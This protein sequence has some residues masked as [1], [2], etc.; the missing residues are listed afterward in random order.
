MTDSNINNLL[1]NKEEKENENKI[2]NINDL[3]NNNEEENKE[4]IEENKRRIGK[5]KI[6]TPETDALFQRFDNQPLSSLSKIINKSNAGIVDFFDNRFLGDQRSFDEIL[7]NRSRLINEAKEKNEKISEELTKTKTSQVIRGSIT[8]PLKA[9]NETVEFVDDIYDYL[10][11]NPYDNNDLIDYS[12]FEREDDGAFFYIPQAITQF[13]LPMGIFSKGLKGIKNPWT[14]NLIA[15]FLTDFIVEDPY[16]QNLYN[17][18]DEYEGALE[19]IIDIFKMPASI[20]KADDDISPIEARL[21]KAFGG[22]V[23]G[24]VLTGLSVALKAFR[25]SK[26][27]PRI[28]TTLEQK[29]KLKFQDLGIDNAGNELLDVKVIDLL[30]PLDI[31][32]TSTKP[33]IYDLP[34]TRG[35]GKFYHG[36]SQEI[37]LFEGGEAISS[38]NIYGNGFYTTDDLITGSKYQKKGKKQILKPEIPIAKGIKKESDLPYGI[39]S[40]LKKLNITNQELNQLTTPSIKVPSSNRLRDLA[41]QAR[42]FPIDN[43]FSGGIRTIKENFNKI[44]DRLDELADNPPRTPDFKPITYEITE[45]QPVN[46]YDLDQTID[47][48]LKTFVNNFDDSPFDDIVSLAANNLGNNYTL[49]ELFDEIRAYSNARGVSSNTVIDDIFGSFQDYF[50]EKGFGGFTHEGGKKAGK[51]KRLHQVRIYFDP[52]NQ[53]DLNK[54][55]FDDILPTPEVGDKIESTFNPTIT[56]GGV[57]QLEDYILNISE[58]FK[59]TDELGKWARSVSLGDMF[60]ASQ[61][62]TNGQAIEAAQFFLQEFGPFKKTTNGKLINN[63]RYLPSTTITINQLMNKNGERV[64]NLSTALHNAIALKNVDLIKEIKPAFLKEVQLLKDIVYLNKGV[65]SLTSQTLGARRIAGDLRDVGATAEDFGKKSRGTENIEDINKQFIEDEGVSEIDQTFNKIFDLVE[66]GDEEA[67]LALTR[68]TKYLNIAG[69]NPEVMKHMVK[70]GLLLKGVEFTNEIFINSILSGPPTHIVNLLS[71]SLNTLAKPLTQSLGAA[72]ITFRK[73]MNITFPETILKR[74]DNL[75][76]RP[77]FNTDEFIKGWKQFIYMSQSLGDAFNIARKAFQVNENVLDRGAMVSD[78][79]RVSRNINAEDIRNFANQNIVTRSTVKPFLDTRIAETWIPS[80][81]NNFRR[82]NGFGSRMLITEDE[83]LKQVNFRSYVKAESWEQGI[84]KGLQGEKLKNYIQTQSEKVFKIVDTGSTRK[85]PTSITDLYKKA[86]DYAAEVTF[87][88]DLDPRSFSGG[89]QNFAKHPYGRVVF[90]FVRTPINIFKTQMRY[91]FAVNTVMS[92]YR[93]ALRSTDP[94]IAARARGEMYLAGGFLSMGALIARDMENPFAEVGMTGGGPNTVGFGDAI[95]ANRILVKQLKEEGWQ[96]YS[97]RFLVRDSDGEIVLTKSGKPKYKYISFKRL[98]PWSGL[99][100]ILAD[101]VDVEGQIGS[102]N[103]NDFA[104]AFVVSVARNLT[105]RTFLRGL[106]EVAEAIHNPYALQSLLARRVANIINPVSG[107]G[108]SLKKATDKTKFDTTYY[109]ADEM[110]TG[111]RQILNEL[112]RTMP[113]YN[114]DLE[115]DRNWLT[116]AVVKY[117]SGLGPDTFDILNPI[118][119]TTTKDN[120]V[121]SVIN[122]LNITLQPPKK[123]FLRRQGIQNSGIELTRK[124]YSSY[125]KYLSFDTKSFNFKTASGYKIQDGDRLI[126]SLY[127]R[128]NEPDMKAYIKTAMGEGID[129]TNQDTMVAVQDNARAIISKEI[130]SI[131]SNFKVKARNEWL[132]LPE[133]KKLFAKY[134]ANMEVISNETTKATLNNLEEIKNL[135]N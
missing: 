106:T 14:R 108:R 49:G 129:S 130:Q 19:P 42:Q 89:I 99:F 63:P 60:A 117:P 26:F 80:I 66:Q 67:A 56:G 31:K 112:T 48:D 28:L 82:I 62:Q 90:P 23:I 61:R 119:A 91:T 95:E 21:R 10:A 70:K 131:V 5:G 53:I 102:Q 128:L 110:L 72:K 87:T 35:Q 94:N 45:K 43:P 88:K 44:A 12:Y 24:E 25:N 57:E 122:D 40:D 27:A 78:A 75:A 109:P 121:L 97:F 6:E 93:Q 92:E 39:Q 38:Q 29:R 68:L 98:D 118:T 103:T 86:K 124:Q 64:F 17:M 71:T 30:K 3:L 32:K 47:A 46:F 104:S 123:F 107:L 22:A 101:F 135:G 96:P 1:N 37:T 59:S 79:Q 111:L 81:Y 83:F 15:G 41:N 18:I 134:T 36:S 84:R 69:G 58:Y 116:G 9:I 73:N 105:D 120:Y 33:K 54:V 133:N 115:P 16:E 76:F 126:I 77:E 74:Q 65:G 125:V 11:G 55:D 34:D 50:K 132:R 52:A 100:M 13:L 2:L 51:A 127:K 85:L 7:E 113:F 8:G 20:F 4:Q 114:A